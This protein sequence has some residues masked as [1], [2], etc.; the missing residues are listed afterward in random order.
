ME[1]TLM[2]IGKIRVGMEIGSGVFVDGIR[3]RGEYS[4]ITLSTGRTYTLH[5]TRHVADL[6][7]GTPESY[8][9]MD[10]HV[11]TVRK[12]RAADSEWRGENVGRRGERFIAR[13]TSHDSRA[14]TERLWRQ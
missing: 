7:I 11:R 3:R 5:K 4:V 10:S 13:N 12:V 6:Q 8:A 9:L 14:V 2:L 1:G